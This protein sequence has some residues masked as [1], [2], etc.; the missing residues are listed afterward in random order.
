MTSRPDDQAAQLPR[1]RSPLRGLWLTSI[2]GAALLI[3]LPIVILTGLLSY[4]AYG[5]QFG[6]AFPGGVGWL[7]LPT[8]DWP[9]DPSW[10]YRLTQGLHVGLGLIIIPVV[11]AKLWSVIPK[12]FAWPPAKSIAQLLERVSLLMLVGGILFEI[13]TGVLNIQYDYIFG[14]SFYTAHYYGAWVFI[15]GFV[16][17]LAIKLPRM[18]TGLRSMSL[19]DVLRTNVA[20]TRPERRD[21]YG[22]VSVDP[23]PPTMSRRG[24]LA[25]VGGGA[26]L[27]AVL[28][29][30][31][32]LGGVT[33]QA[34][35][36]LPRGR[37]RGEGPN[38]FQVNRTAAVAGITPANTGAG[39]RLTLRGGPA[40][41]VLDRAALAAMPQHT[42]RLP[43]ACVEG[44]STTETWTGVRLRDLAA[45]A[46]VDTPAFARVSSVER[47]G[48]FNRAVLQGN[49]VRHPDALLALRVNDA[50]LSL[51]HGYPARI[52]VPAL[53]GVHNTKWV[54]AIEFGVD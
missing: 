46:G 11:L 31:Q 1:W 33:R 49:Q 22:L 4:I 2:L 14:F 45:R 17:H 36:L 44:W 27:V 54:A 37:T 32:T 53:P 5:P 21:P 26:L 23:A 29:A 3:T 40:P 52:I 42:A 10:L 47:R 15:A 8:F 41:V 25:L 9:T 50:D 48:A 16:V 7:K 51:D 38:D 43:I 35:L 28:T 30:G 24:A 6:Q 34:A 20:D 19:R 12:L 39:W 18:W 13:V